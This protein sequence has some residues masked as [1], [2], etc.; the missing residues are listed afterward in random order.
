MATATFCELN[1][2]EEQKPAVSEL[3]LLANSKLMWLYPA[4][5]KVGLILQ[6]FV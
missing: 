6:R 2:C 1:K 3:L 5:L 4:F